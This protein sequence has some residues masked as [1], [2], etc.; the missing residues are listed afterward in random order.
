MLGLGTV[1][2]SARA[3]DRADPDPDHLVAA[4]QTPS[5]EL[6]AAAPPLLR[7]TLVAAA[8]EERKLFNPAKV[9][10]TRYRYRDS[11]IPSPWPTT[12]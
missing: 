8:S 5:D 2:K 10:T 4:A 3:E 12:G 1:R 9:H 7:R 11:V 6:E